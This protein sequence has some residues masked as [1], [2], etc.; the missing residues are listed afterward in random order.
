[1]NKKTLN[2]IIEQEKTIYKTNK[3][4]K[5]EHKK[6]VAKREDFNSM[7]VAHLLENRVGHPV[8]LS[9]IE[10]GVWDSIKF[11]L[12]KLGSLE[13]GGKIFGDRKGRT[14]AAEKEMMDSIDKASSEAVNTMVSSIKNEYPGWPN[15][16]DS[17]KFAASMMVFYIAYD[18]IVKA[19]KLQP[20]DPKY[21]HPEA[22]N[23]AIEAITKVLNFTKD[24]KL[25]DI[26]KHT[27]EQE[28][29]EGEV[30]EEISIPA[31]IRMTSRLAR[32]VA[33]DGFESLSPRQALRLKRNVG[34]LT[35]KA[36]EAGGA[37]NLTATEEQALRIGRKALADS[38][39]AP[40]GMMDFD[41]DSLAGDD[42]DFGGGADAADAVD[43]GGDA[44]DAA[45]VADVGGDAADAVDV[46]ADAADV[47]D[48]GG[49]AADVA[50]VGGD[51]AD[52]ADVGGDAVDVADVGGGGGGGEG[53]SEA[54]MAAANS[55]AL[56]T[57]LAQ[58]GITLA[59]G[60][61]A[62]AFGRYKMAKSSRN[63]QI[64]DM[65]KKMKPVNVPAGQ[66]LGP[67][68]GEEQEG[69]EGGG[70]EGG[71]GGEGEQPPGIDPPGPGP[72][73]PG[74]GPTTPGT[75]DDKAP[76]GDI[77]VFRG[78]GGKG[79]QSQFAKS[80][81]KG[82]DMSRLMK[83]LRGDLTAAGFNVLEEAKRET[84]SLEQTLAAL[85][86]IEDAS[87][88][89]AAKAAI[90]QMLRKH[91]VRLDPQSSMALRPAQG[92]E[93]GG[94]E[95]KDKPVAPLVS[96]EDED[97]PDKDPPGPETPDVNVDMD[98]AAARAAAS[99][100]AQA[101]RGGPKTGITLDP[102]G[103]KKPKVNVDMDAAARRAAASNRQQQARGAPCPDGQFRA[104]DG[105]CMKMGGR[106]GM[107]SQ[108][109]SIAKHADML[110]EGLTFNRWAKIAGII[111]G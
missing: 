96:Y 4:I 93:Q 99:N 23:G 35:A 31:M 3:S 106:A 97:V 53:M 7:V 21:M 58:M 110:E 1:M 102:P 85:E 55:A 82:G 42:V 19:T 68:E 45:D 61:A 5:T 28:E 17:N 6:L 44:A 51:A 54:A 75:D 100:K 9:Q 13:K 71:E 8:D 43:V 18:S 91:K 66:E 92:G 109:E 67:P 76:R 10:E 65:T 56:K 25:A 37:E 77:Y 63:Q 50:D 24:Y 48:V 22:A 69:G 86:Q 62:L 73:T 2:R 104:S 79:M 88:K 64:Q 90:V 103:E 78:K 38:S 34:R 105:K 83:G 81:I 41:P 46:G 11:G 80:G 20:D 108:E 94:G 72:T 111:K 32:K 26:Y 107:G 36:K 15:I 47:A 60:A 12:S 29:L 30:L 33:N 16:K 98:A 40:E 87:Q 14:A 59:I 27:N 57:M 39:D 74:Q 52:V 95:G 49:D 101:A 89:E 84:I 70:G